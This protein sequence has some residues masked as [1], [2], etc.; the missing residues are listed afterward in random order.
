MAQEHE[1]TEIV[2][3]P[4]KYDLMLALIDGD[5]KHR[6]TVKFRV[7]KSGGLIFLG[8][9]MLINCLEREDGSGERWMFEGY[10]VLSTGGWVPMKGFYDTHVRKGWVERTE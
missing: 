10:H 3:G 2:E 1:H 4:S 9:T 7:D 8:M 5:N 6:R